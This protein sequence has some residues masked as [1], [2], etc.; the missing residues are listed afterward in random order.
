LLWAF[1]YPLYQ[2]IG[3]LRHEASHALAAVLEG[4]TIEEFVFWPTRGYWGY[5]RW[6]G[7]TTWVSTAAPY[8]VDLV[9]Y[10]VFFVI[11][12][13]VRF[14]RQWVWVNLVALGLVS[15]LVNSAYNYFRSFSRTNDVKKLL[16]SKPDLP[17]HTYFVATLAIYVAGFVYLSLTR[18]VSRRSLPR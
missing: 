2:I 3:T 13:R 8:F 6:S 14:K 9:T 16:I 4:A 1:A 17:I 11:C 15:P 10:A 7:Q 12:T 5:V 18:K